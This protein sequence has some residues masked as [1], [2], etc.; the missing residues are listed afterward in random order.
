MIHAAGLLLAS[1]GLYAPAAPAD[2]LAGVFRRVCLEGSGRFGPGEA[3]SLRFQDLPPPVKKFLDRPGPLQDHY[4]WELGRASDVEGRY[5]GVGRGDS[6]GFLAVRS[7]RRR[8]VDLKAC[9]LAT[10]G[11]GFEAAIHRLDAKPDLRPDGRI[12]RATFTTYSWSSMSSLG[13]RLTV[14]KLDQDYVALQALLI[15]P[16]AA[17]REIERANAR[18]AKAFPLPADPGKR[19]PNP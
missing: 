16:E 5:F 11:I 9:V 13:Y 12:G 1:S 15:P 8:D 6:K 2:E 10:R 14:A 4:Q 17:Q 19:E 7:L 3:R 18:R